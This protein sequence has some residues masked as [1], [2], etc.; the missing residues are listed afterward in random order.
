VQILILDEADRLLDMGF[1]K[2]I[3][4]IITELPK[5]RRT[6]LFSAT[7]TQAV[8]ELAKAGLRNPVRVEVR[9]E[10]K[11]ANDSA[12]SKKT[13]SSKTPSGLHIEVLP[14]W[15]ASKLEIRCVVISFFHFSS[16]IPSFFWLI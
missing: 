2:Q 1:Q 5:L 11:T 13:E 3:N 7:Q 12:A 4:A 10:T 16:R 15:H 9:A 14:M 8:E 6:G